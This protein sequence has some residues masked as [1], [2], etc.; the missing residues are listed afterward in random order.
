MLIKIKSVTLYH[1]TKRNK[2]I[3]LTKRKIMATK[4]ADFLKYVVFENVVNVLNG[5]FGNRV[6]KQP[7]RTIWRVLAWSF[8]VYA[9]FMLFMVP[10]FGAWSSVVEFLNDIIW[11]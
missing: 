3:H 11:G 4:F 5:K 8:F 10:L 9:I 7:L 2:I 6:L 1:E